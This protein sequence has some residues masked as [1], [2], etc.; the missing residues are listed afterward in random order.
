M[1][2]MVRDEGGLIL[3]LFN[4]YINACSKQMKGYVDDINGDNSNG[5]IASRV[6]LDA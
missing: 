4:N 3:P 1:A 2:M 6:W 5:H